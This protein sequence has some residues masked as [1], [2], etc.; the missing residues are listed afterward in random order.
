MINIAGTVFAYGVTSSGKTHTMHVSVTFKINVLIFSFVIWSIY[1]GSQAVI[2]YLI[3]IL[4]H[5]LI[6]HIAT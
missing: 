1:D 4:Q 6:H 3:I 2:F 5:F